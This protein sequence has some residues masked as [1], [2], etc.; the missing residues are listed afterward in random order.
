MSFTCSSPTYQSSETSSQYKDIKDT[1]AACLCIYVSLMRKSCRLSCM[2]C[3]E[4]TMNPRMSETDG[5]LHPYLQHMLYTVLNYD[6]ENISLSK[7]H[8]IYTMSCEPLNVCRVAERTLS[9]GVICITP[10]SRWAKGSDCHAS[11]VISVFVTRNFSFRLA[12]S[13]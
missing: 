9:P 13:A 4:L 1:A 6:I 7:I 11:R 10:H 12:K 5:N 3:V 2:Y 8:L